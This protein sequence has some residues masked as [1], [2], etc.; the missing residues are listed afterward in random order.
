[1]VITNRMTVGLDKC[2]LQCL[3]TQL[4]RWNIFVQTLED[5]PKNFLSHKKDYSNRSKF[6][7]IKNCL[8]LVCVLLKFDPEQKNCL[9]SLYVLTPI[10]LHLYHLHICKLCMNETK[11]AKK[12][13]NCV[14]LWL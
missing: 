9:T 1:M 5:P 7:N 3:Q 2:K 13:L 10:E 11:H 4:G 12:T 6:K 14:K 8:R